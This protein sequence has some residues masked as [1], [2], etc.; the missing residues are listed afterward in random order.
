MLRSSLRKLYNI[1]WKK[2][3]KN[4]KHY[5]QPRL[6]AL[7]QKSSMNSLLTHFSIQ[8]HSSLVLLLLAFL[9][10][11]EQVNSGEDSKSLELGNIEFNA[12]PD[13]CEGS[14][15]FYFTTTSKLVAEPK[16]GIIRIDEPSENVL[17]TLLIYSG[18]LGNWFVGSRGLG[19]KL[20]TEMR[21]IGYRIVQIK[22]DEGWFIGSPGDNEGFQKLAV[23]PA[24]VTQYIYDE[25][26][27]KEKPFVLFG[28]SGGAAQIAYMLSFYGTDKIASSAVAFGG[29][30]MGRL[31]I[32]CFDNDSLNSFMHY[33]ERARVVIDLSFGFD[34][35]TKGPCELCDTTFMERY[36]NSSVSVG[37]NYYYPNTQ[38]FLIYGGND[39]VGA[40]NQGLTYYHQLATAKS[41]FIH[42]Q[43]IEGAPHGILN[44]STGYDVL[45]NILA[46]QITQKMIESNE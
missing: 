34:P 26:A 21:N 3:F 10:G 23:H 29:F 44:D 27:E 7:N 30:W 14:K 4:R 20:I 42:M 43:I 25:L 36:R 18:G 2:H 5:C 6:V 1:L 8:I 46:A 13:T 37:G 31:D 17:G 40:L 9:A 16:G 33:S 35:E 32:G 28:G 15:C 39:R 24:T 12:D 41:P 38:V 11:C 19:G 45:R 22:W